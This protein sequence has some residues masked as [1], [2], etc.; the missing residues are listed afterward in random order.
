MRVTT[1]AAVV[2]LFLVSVASG[3]EA[4]A[5]IRKPTQIEPQELGAAL[6]QLAREYHFQIVYRDDVVGNLRTQG[7]SGNL[8]PADAL[9]QLLQGTGLSYQYLDENTVTVRPDA[10]HTSGATTA[11]HDSLSSQEEE[12]LAGPSA[13]VDDSP[14][15]R[16]RLAQ[17]T[18]GPS[19][20]TTSV[21]RNNE[22][23][24]LQEVVVTAQKKEERLL[25]VPVPVSVVSG[26]KLTENSQVLLRD[27]YNTVPSLSIQSDI[28]NQQEVSIRGI[29]TGGAGIPTV[30]ITVDGVPFGG[31]T[32]Y[33]GGNWLP[34]FDPG[35]L[36]RVEVLRGPQGTLYGANSMGGLV[37]FVTVDPS[38]TQ[39][40]GRVQAGISDVYNGAVPGFNVRGS[41]NIPVNETLAIR[42]SAFTRQDPGYIDNPTLGQRGV[43]EA[44]AYGARMAALWKPSDTI[45]LR[46][47]ALYQ[48]YKQDAANDVV[49]APGLGPWDQNYIAHYGG[50]NRRKNQ[51]Y[52][53]IANVK[54]GSTLLTSVT[55][56][57]ENR[58][59]ASLDFGYSPYF[60]SG[61]QNMFG[62]TGAPYTNYNDTR[63]ITEELR[64]AGAL[65]KMDWLLG[66]FY[67]HEKDPYYDAVYGSDPVT[68]KIVGLFYPFDDRSWR[69]GAEY[70]G[71]ANLTFHATDRFDVQIGGRQSHVSL[72]IPEYSVSGGIFGSTPFITPTENSSNS[73]FTYLIAPELKISPDLMVYARA[74]SGFRPGGSN[75]VVPNVPMPRQVAPDK[76]KNYEIGTKGSLFDDKLTI[77][78]SVYYI[79]WKNIQINLQAQG[80]LYHANGS[81]AKSEGVEFAATARP[82]IG[83]TI[84]GWAAYDNAVLT[85]PFPATSTSSANAGDRLPISPRW[86]AHLSV[87]QEFPLR[88]A[89]GFVGGDVAYVGDRL[90]NFSSDTT[91]RTRFPAYTKVDLRTGVKIDS[92]TASL[93]VTNVGNARG[94]VGGG[95]GY[96]PPNAF[97][98]ITPRIVGLNLAK[99]FD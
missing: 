29:T 98:Y 44:Q 39:Y 54:L 47:S 21:E 3:G 27:Y 34:D 32:N 15:T 94:L 1:V 84:E 92:W 30:G 64:L 10:S 25:D 46:V 49:E 38:T 57:S 7:A 14:W 2:S 72:D 6:Q 62:V 56:Y 22:Q 60:E 86:S 16:F 33:S 55:G 37:N 50:A 88:S 80:L 70:A 76:T 40:S 28:V 23:A 79:D 68:G 59:Y 96:D 42:L 12:D 91:L 45:S 51:V 90:G 5:A 26:A 31:S 18:Q 17:A 66:G 36:Q 77:D 41:A 81:A 85:E 89:V 95:V 71:F 24:P 35:D 61:V 75:A 58:S 65:W 8:T 43:N 69:I 74:S 4:L 19:A 67:S 87:T 9:K 53:A 11:L 48:D 20:E 52:S 78:A 99:T 13:R 93:Y 73:V 97:V 82:V 83:L 63:R